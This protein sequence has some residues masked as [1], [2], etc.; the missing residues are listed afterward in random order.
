MNESFNKQGMS[1]DKSQIL[2]NT[3]LAPVIEEEDQKS[4]ISFSKGGENTQNML[5]SLI[6]E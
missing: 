5:A 3:N 1:I 4:D 2:N 6:N